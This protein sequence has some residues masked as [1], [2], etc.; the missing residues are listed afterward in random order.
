[1][2]S[3]ILLTMEKSLP[4]HLVASKSGFNSTNY[5][6]RTFSRKLGCSPT[7]FRKTNIKAP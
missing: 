3:Q 1:M 5:F 4:I 7:V 2:K 6:G